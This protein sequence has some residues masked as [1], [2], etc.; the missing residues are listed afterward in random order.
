MHTT[1]GSS[2]LSM[3]KITNGVTM[4]AKNKLQIHTQT[5]AQVSCS[6]LGGRWFECRPGYRM[7]WPMSSV[8]FLSPSRDKAVGIM[9]ALQV[10]QT[11]HGLRPGGSRFIFPL[12]PSRPVLWAHPASYP[13][14]NGC[15]FPRG[16]AAEMWRWPLICK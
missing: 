16:K 10:G 11:V 12:S 14:G 15:P 8:I 9:T 7:H 5:L 6:Y 4:E 1:Q 13:M 2:T 3:T